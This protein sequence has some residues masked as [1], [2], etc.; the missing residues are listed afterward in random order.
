[1]YAFSRHLLMLLDRVEVGP[2]LLPV[3]V[4]FLIGRKA[5]EEHPRLRAIG[6]H[7]AGLF[8][9]IWVLRAVWSQPS[10]VHELTD[11]VLRSA[12]ISG[13]L[14]GTVWMALPLLAWLTSKLY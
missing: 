1:M 7:I 12:C 10:A 9:V 2:A 5:V 14:L 8:F 6:F 13:L 4:F 11:V 3:I